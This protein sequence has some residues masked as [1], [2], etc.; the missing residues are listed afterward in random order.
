SSPSTSVF[1]S[2]ASGSGT[3]EVLSGAALDLTGPASNTLTF[4]SKGV[5]IA[6]AGPDGNGAIVNNGNWQQWAF[7]SVSLENDATVGG[8][9]R[10]DIRV[11]GGAAQLDLAGH[12]LTKTGSNQ[13]TVVGANVTD[14]NIVANSGNFGL[15]TA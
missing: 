2:L 14:G 4:G 1:G 5:Y 9:G 15:E 11:N 7:Q 12:T 3:V 8:T 10:I 6:G 13:F